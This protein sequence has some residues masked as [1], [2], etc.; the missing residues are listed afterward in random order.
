VA[1]VDAGA[2]E[3]V[4]DGEDEVGVMAQPATESD[5][6]K[7]STIRTATFFRHIFHSSDLLRHHRTCVVALRGIGV[8]VLHRSRN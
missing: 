3:S 4:G 5:A 6:T 2:G 1:G 7:A 8:G